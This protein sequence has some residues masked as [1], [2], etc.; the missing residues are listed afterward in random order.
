MM[1]SGITTLL[2]IGKNGVR[3]DKSQTLVVSL[4]HHTNAPVHICRMAILQIIGKLFG[5]IRADIERLMTDQHAL[6]E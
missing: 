4:P 5:D 1:L 6:F 3:I 2:E